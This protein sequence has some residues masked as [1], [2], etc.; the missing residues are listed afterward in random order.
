MTDKCGEATS[1]RKSCKWPSHKQT[2]QHRTPV[3]FAALRSKMVALLLLIE[4]SF[5]FSYTISNKCTHILT[6]L[7]SVSQKPDF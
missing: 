2:I 5:E 4:L 6:M 3:A 7:V 1:K